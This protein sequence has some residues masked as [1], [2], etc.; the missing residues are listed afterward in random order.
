[1][2]LQFKEQ[3]FQLEAVNAVC[4]L[5]EGQKMSYSPF[6]VANTIN[7]PLNFADYSTINHIDLEED[8]IL[9][10]MHS[11]QDKNHLPRT[12]DLAGCSSQ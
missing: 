11:V 10:N 12:D 2:K 8:V 7:T 9:R 3:D 4:S 6:T 5:F 1:M